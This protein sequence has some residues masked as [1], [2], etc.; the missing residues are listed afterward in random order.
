[1]PQLHDLKSTRMNHS[2][3]FL[4][5][6]TKSTIIDMTNI[7]KSHKIKKLYIDD[8]YGGHLSFFA[9][10][11]VAKAIYSKISIK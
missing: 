6:K 3:F 9:Y 1:M 11:L 4:N 5:L 2:K 7:F 8:F 10:Y